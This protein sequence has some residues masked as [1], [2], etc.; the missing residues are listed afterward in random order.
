MVTSGQCRA[1]PALCLVIV[2]PTAGTPETEQLW[3]VPGGPHQ[4]TEE[5]GSVLQ[6]LLRSTQLESKRST[7]DL[8]LSW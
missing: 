8:T 5:T 7:E 6:V 4:P 2:A 3:S 1:S